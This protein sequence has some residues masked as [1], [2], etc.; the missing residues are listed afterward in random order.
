MP[1]PSPVSD[2]QKQDGRF[3]PGRSG[4]PTGKRPGTRNR[5]LMLLDKLGE[6]SAA[7]VMTSVIAAART[8]D[9]AAARVI[10]DRVWPARRARPVALDLPAVT[11]AEGVTAAL[12][13]VAAMSAGIIT[14]DE[15]VA[16]AGVIEA[17]RRAIETTELVFRCKQ[18]VQRIAASP[19]AATANFVN[20]PIVSEH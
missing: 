20:H 5:N 3:R 1:Q 8:G 17:Q 9:I 19:A 18:M 12:A 15:A 2:L 6:A 7:S 16:A 14:P 11:S 13:V 4:N 10:L